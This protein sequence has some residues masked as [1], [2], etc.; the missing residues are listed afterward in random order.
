MQKNSNICYICCTREILFVDGEQDV[1]FEQYDDVPCTSP[2]DTLDCWVVTLPLLFKDF[3][4]SG[5]YDAPM[6]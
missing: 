2:P 6:F 5:G 1:S 3:G 4:D